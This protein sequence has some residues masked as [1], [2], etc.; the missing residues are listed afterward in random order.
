MNCTPNS[1]KNET[2]TKPLK[3]KLVKKFLHNY[4]FWRDEKLAKAPTKIQ[5]CMVEIKD[6][7]KLSEV[8]KNQIRDL[9]QQ[10]NFAL[11]QLNMPS[12]YTD[13][14]KEMNAQFGLVDF[15]K[16]LYAQNQGLACI[17]KTQIPQQADF[18]PYTDKALGWHTD[19]YYNAIEQRIRAFSLFCVHPAAEGGANQWIDPQMVYLL[20][21]QENMD[22]VKALAHPQAMSIPEHRVA[23]KV[24]RVRSTGGIF[25]IDEA[26]DTLSMRYTQR[27]KNIAFFNSVEITQAVQRL[28]DLLKTKTNHHFEHLMQSGQG[29]LCNNVLHKR[30][31]FS[32][33]K[34]HPRLLLRGRYFNKIGYPAHK[35]R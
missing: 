12:D 8:E 31:A 17:T 26:T 27:K 22:I 11:F 30:A 14:I 18:I 15:D 35:N 19:G 29:L 24:R 1:N 9:C 32:D 20:L 5:Q 6:A 28:D 7:L 33:D 23:G 34:T 4:P 16:H 21:A 3:P 10:G 13:A 2:K 25:F